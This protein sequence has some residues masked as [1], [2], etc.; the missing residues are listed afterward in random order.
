ML[1]GGD[2][3]TPGAVEA[4]IEG[5]FGYLHKPFVWSELDYLVTLALGPRAANEFN[6]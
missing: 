6:L 1:T 4:F 5:A 3:G 2:S